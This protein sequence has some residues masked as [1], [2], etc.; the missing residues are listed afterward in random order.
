MFP[1][2]RAQGWPNIGRRVTSGPARRPTSSKR[3]TSA[4][5]GFSNFG[6]SG[7]TLTIPRPPLARREV[8]FRGRAERLVA[9]TVAVR[10]PRSSS[11]DDP[12]PMARPRREQAEQVG[13]AAGRSARRS[14]GSERWASPT[15]T[16]SVPERAR[17]V[18]S[19]AVRGPIPGMVR[20]AAASCSACRR[21]AAGRPRRWP[22]AAPS[23]AA[24]GEPPPGE[25]RS[26]RHEAPWRDREH[27]RRRRRGQQRQRPRRPVPVPPH[28]APV[29][30]PRLRP[31]DPLLEDRRQERLPDRAG[32][33]QSRPTP[34]PRQLG[35][36]RMQAR[37]EP[38]VVVVEAEQRGQAVQEERRPSTPVHAPGSRCRP[39]GA[40]S[41]QARQG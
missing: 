4:G 33:P 37:F 15:L 2:T 30:S 10:S 17:S 12:R 7:T 31:G 38:R 9:R 18:T 40:R 6:I 8:A 20:R 13:A 28:E 16:A 27:V 1:P 14:R 24:G 25:A 23:R 36:R 39:P 26:R 29:V 19:A 5:V 34:A 21:R 3:S 11:L 22:R 32:A 41:I 35:N